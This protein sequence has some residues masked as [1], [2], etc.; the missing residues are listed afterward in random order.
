MQARRSTQ[1]TAAPPAGRTRRY[2]NNFALA[3]LAEAAAATADPT[4]AAAAAANR[5][6]ALRAQVAVHPDGFDPVDVE[7]AVRL[8]GTWLRSFDFQRWEPYAQA[9]D[10]AWGPWVAEAGHGVSLITITLAL[11]ERNTSMWDVVTGDPARR[12]RYAALA[13][14]L[15]PLYFPPSRA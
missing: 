10:W 9:S 14:E 8:D 4:L 12:A 5:E 6:F 11:M 7:N 13:A 2:S 3:A 1:P 15:T